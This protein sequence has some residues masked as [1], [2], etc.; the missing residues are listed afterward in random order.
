MYPSV[1]T[2]QG[3]AG[4]G[5]IPYVSVSMF[6]D[7]G[8]SIGNLKE[9]WDAVRSSENMLGGFIWDWVDQ[10]RAVDLND[11]GSTYK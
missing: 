2:V 5:K 1:G 7:M 4:E 10:A 6:M 9:Y 8:N 3:R 11:L